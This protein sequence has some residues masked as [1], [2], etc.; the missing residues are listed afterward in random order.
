MPTFATPFI[1]CDVLARI[2]WG[3]ENAKLH[4]CVSQTAQPPFP[5]SPESECDGCAHSRRDRMHVNIELRWDF[6]TARNTLYACKRPK[7]NIHFQTLITISGA[8]KVCSVSQTLLAPFSDP[9]PRVL[10]V[11]VHE[12]VLAC[13]GDELFPNIAGKS[14]VRLLIPNSALSHALG[15]PSTHQGSHTCPALIVF[16]CRLT[17][18]NR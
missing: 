11:V 7:D 17:S 4:P 1:F 3:V 16:S 5:I 18:G 14:S 9:N 6:C 8:V 10:S 15:P 2:V 12:G 13:T